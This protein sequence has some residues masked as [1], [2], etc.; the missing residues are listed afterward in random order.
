MYDTIM[1]TIIQGHLKKYNNYNI[2]FMFLSMLLGIVPFKVGWSKEG[3]SGRGDGLDEGDVMEIVV[4]L[5]VVLAGEDGGVDVG[6]DGRGGDGV[7]D[8]W[9]SRWA[10]LWWWW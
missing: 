1:F 2:H 5:D 3:Y 8:A 4:W 6:G 7:G 9:R 10:W